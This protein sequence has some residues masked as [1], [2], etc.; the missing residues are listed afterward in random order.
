[1]GP[2]VFMSIPVAY[3]IYD[4]EEPVLPSRVATLASKSRRGPTKQ[5]NQGRS[6]KSCVC[7]KRPRRSRARLMHYETHNPAL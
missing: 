5:N 1:M 3:V 6:S 4:A 7:P 2:P